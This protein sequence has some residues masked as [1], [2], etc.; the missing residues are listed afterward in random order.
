MPSHQFGANPSGLCCPSLYH[1]KLKHA[2]KHTCLLMADLARPVF[3]GLPVSLLLLIKY[4]ESAKPPSAEKKAEARRTGLKPFGWR[5]A[6]NSLLKG[7]QQGSG[8]NLSPLDWLWLLLA[9]LQRWLIPPRAMT[10]CSQSH[11]GLLLE[12]WRNPGR[13]MTNF[14]RP[15]GLIFWILKTHKQGWH[16]VRIFFDKNINT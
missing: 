7:Q 14:H 9:S 6:F 15:R 10:D 5:L 12:P 3:V 8:R 11:D 13:A 2:G 16:Y 4:S 1:C